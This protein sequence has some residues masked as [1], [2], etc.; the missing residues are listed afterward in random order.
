M[1]VIVE[2]GEKSVLKGRDPIPRFWIRGSD[3]PPFV[4][5]RDT[6]F[7]CVSSLNLGHSVLRARGGFFFAVPTRY[8]AAAGKA[9]EWAIT[10]SASITAR[11]KPAV[12]SRPLPG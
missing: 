10:L 6:P 3:V 5:P 2:N 4:G 11:T 1:V 12:R 7:R 8:S 9:C